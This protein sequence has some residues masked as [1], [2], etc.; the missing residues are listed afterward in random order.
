M[1]AMPNKMVFGIGLGFLGGII[2]LAAMAYSWDGT[3]NCMPLVGLNMLVAAMFFATAGTFSKVT[4]VAGNTIVVIA[5][6]CEAMVIL[7]MLYEATFVWVNLILAV[8]G[9][10]CILIGACPTVSGWV[11]A[12]RV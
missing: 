9:A 5:A 10:A 11:D 1:A 4:P 2:A 3:V 6:V 7:S 8:I 12:Q